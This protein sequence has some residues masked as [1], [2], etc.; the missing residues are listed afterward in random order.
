MLQRL[1]LKT[2][3]TSIKK[4]REMPLTQPSALEALMATLRKLD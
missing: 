3:L 4:L 1:R 2:G